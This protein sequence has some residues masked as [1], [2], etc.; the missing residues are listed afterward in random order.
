MTYTTDGRSENATSGLCHGYS[1]VATGQANRRRSSERRAI[2]HQ[3]QASLSTVH[4]TPATNHF[5]K[6]LSYCRSRTE[7]M[8]DTILCIPCSFL[9]TNSESFD[10][11][12][13]STPEL[14][15]R[16]VTLLLTLYKHPPLES[17]QCAEYL[18]FVLETATFWL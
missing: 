1:V 15:R 4:F 11:A 16:I 13:P 10:L 9:R 5:D 17:S 2:S 7:H 8:S 14:V 3:Q 18:V 6:P 12:V